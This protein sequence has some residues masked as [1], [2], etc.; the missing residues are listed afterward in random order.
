MLI[1]LIENM[2]ILLLLPFICALLSF[3]FTYLAIPWLIK[4]LKRIDLVV[5]DQHKKYKVLV[6]ISGGLAVLSGMLGGLMFFIFV[7]TFFPT[8]TYKLVLN[9][10]TLSLLFATIISILII[11]MVGF[12]DDLLIRK[13]KDSSMG[14]KQWQKPL[15]TLSAAIPLM[16]VNAGTTIMAVPFLGKVNFGIL[17]PLVLVP[18]GVVGA[19][20][21]VNMLAGFN[22]LE[23]GL[24]LIYLSSLG[25]YA[26][27]FGRYIAALLALMAFVA[28]LAFYLY[29]K[30]PSKIFPGDSLT[31]LLGA[32]LASIAI[33]GDLEQATLIISIPFIVEFFLKI[34]GKLQKQTYGY[35]ENGKIKS[36]YRKIYSLPH[37]FTR[38][39]K[40]TERQVVLF[41]WII[42][43]IFALLIWII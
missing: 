18:L 30:Y 4:Y 40:F 22:G 23:A 13:S 6:P 7:R 24:A 15:L 8:E 25:L 31:Y 35:N 33:V 29:N 43:A 34:R 38:T 37:I 21:M 11:T 1:F 3:S 2:N 17:Y 20:N 9:D 12:V 42:Q 41:I 10:R 27:K 39:G 19:S 36:F 32:V 26:Y 14:L 28:V 5:L 16:V